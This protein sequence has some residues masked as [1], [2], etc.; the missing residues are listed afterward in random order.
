MLQNQSILT[1]EQ[2]HFPA[3][4]VLSNFLGADLSLSPPAIYKRENDRPSALH[5]KSRMAKYHV[6]LLAVSSFSD[7]PYLKKPASF[8]EKSLGKDSRQYWSGFEGLQ[9]G[10]GIAVCLC[11]RCW[12]QREQRSWKLLVKESFQ[13]QLMIGWAICPSIM[14]NHTN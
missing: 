13:I 1:K 11:L 9:V 3:E 5:F 12:C 4:A 14:A 2:R 6:E 8:T 10:F 7:I